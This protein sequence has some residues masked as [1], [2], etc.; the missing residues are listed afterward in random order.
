M[1]KD[2]I[3]CWV[4][5]TRKT[6]VNVKGMKIHERIDV[7]IEENYQEK[8]PLWLLNNLILFY[9]RQ[10]PPKTDNDNKISTV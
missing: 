9:E 6:G 2:L 10:L 4:I 1:Q 7:E 5:I 3:K 8:R